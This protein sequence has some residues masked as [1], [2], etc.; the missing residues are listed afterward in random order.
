MFTRFFKSFL[1]FF[2]LI[3]TFSSCFRFRMSDSTAFKRYGQL[4]FPFQIGRY[5]APPYQIRYLEIGYDSLPVVLFL[6]GG[7]GTASTYARYLEDS[8]LLRHFK[9]VTVDRPGHGYSN[10][11]KTEVS[12][13]RQ[14]EFLKPLLEKLRRNTPSVFLVGH[15]Y[16]GTIAA[17]MAMDYPHLIDKMILSAP[18]IDPD[19]EKRFWFNRPLN[20]FLIKW[21]MPQNFI[22]AND[23]KLAHA[24]ECRKISPDWHKIR[25]PTVYLHGKNDDIVPF[26]NIDFAK[27]KLTNAPVEYI[28]KDSLPHIFVMNQPEVL[29]TILLKMKQL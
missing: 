7:L 29:R 14:S 10:F 9:I 19:N 16:G 20:C 11:G 22:I 18:A 8:I 17:K 25:T 27:K 28:V 5:S 21:A 2:L 1:V 15:S 13:A 26:I 23:E 4:G 12:V 6:H 3:F 24:E